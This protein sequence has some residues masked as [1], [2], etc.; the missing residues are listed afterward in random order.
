VQVMLGQIR[1]VCR[2]CRAQ[3]KGGYTVE[4]R[5]KVLAEFLQP[6]NNAKSR[7][8]MAFCTFSISAPEHSRGRLEGCA[9][10]Q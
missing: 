6:P 3:R 1:E 5:L 2:P 4:H 10:C 9:G 7:V 8:A